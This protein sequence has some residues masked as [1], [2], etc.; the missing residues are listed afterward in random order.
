VERLIAIGAQA[1]RPRPATHQWH[2]TVRAVP[3]LLVMDT[4]NRGQHVRP[5]CA[6]ASVHFLLDR[7]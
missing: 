1:T 5:D 2:A 7:L 3:D 4:N 6:E